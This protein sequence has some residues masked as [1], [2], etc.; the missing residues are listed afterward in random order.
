MAPRPEPLPRGW[1]ALSRHPYRL[2][3]R[4]PENYDQYL[5]RSRARYV[6]TIGRSIVVYRVD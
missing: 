6:T 5:G 4:L 3:F 2:S 1:F